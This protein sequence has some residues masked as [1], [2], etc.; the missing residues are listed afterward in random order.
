MVLQERSY[1]GLMPAI[2]T[3]LAYLGTPVAHHR[4]PFGRVLATGSAVFQ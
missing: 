4:R 3:I 1:P 2:L